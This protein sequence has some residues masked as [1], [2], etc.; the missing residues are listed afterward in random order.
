VEQRKEKLNVALAMAGPAAQVHAVF[1]VA[2][3]LGAGAPDTPRP[4]KPIF[5]NRARRK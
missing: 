1:A 2:V 3:A 4:R 5:T